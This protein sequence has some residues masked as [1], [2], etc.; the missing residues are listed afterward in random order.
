MKL[1]IVNKM[2]I[3][4]SNPNIQPF[5]LL[6]NK[7][8]VHFIS[9]GITWT[10]VSSYVYVNMFS[11]EHTKALMNEQISDNPFAT[12][13][14]LK[15]KEDTIYYEQEILNGL[16]I[17]FSQQPRLRARLYETRGKELVYEDP[18]ILS[19]LNII[20]NKNVIF[21]PIRGV[22]VPRKEVVS[23]IAGVEKKILE[24]PYLDN[25]LK[26]KDLIQY[27]VQNSPDIP[28]SDEIFINV[29]NIV[30]IL[31]FRLREKILTNNIQKFKNHLIDVYLDYL[32]ETEYPNVKKSDYRKAKFQQIVKEKNIE[33]YENQLFDMYL[34]NKINII[35]TTRLKFTPDKNLEEMN[36]EKKDIDSLLKTPE[37]EGETFKVYIGSQNL[38]LPSFPEEV[39][40]NNKTFNTVVHYAYFKL[41]QRIKLNDRKIDVNTIPLNKLQEMYDYEKNIWMKEK[42]KLNNEVAT[43]AKFKQ[44]EILFHLLQMTS[45]WSPS[46]QENSELIWNDKND[47]VLGSGYDNRGENLTGRF[48]EYLKDQPNLFGINISNRKFSSDNVWY[49]SWLIFKSQDYLNTIKL[50]TSKPTLTDL[51][52][53]Y[54]VNDSIQLKKKMTPSK[55]E[56]QKM[57]IAGLTIEEINLIFPLIEVSK[58]WMNN[59]NEKQVIKKWVEDNEKIYKKPNIKLAENNL[60]LIFDNINKNGSRLEC[61]ENTFIATILAG[62]P[63]DDLNDAKW[64]RI[65]YWS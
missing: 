29:N 23:V 54:R 36:N 13:Q 38:F 52:I 5:G 3:L 12:M 46:F 62:K 33:K 9:D 28:Y 50:F 58:K 63:S 25:N 56:F 47:P 37:I 57:K 51:E 22:E 45:T 44:N 65:K 55:R 60:K 64:Q 32:L 18:K 61:N 15:N 39:T 14:M 41:M 30:P 21:D 31:K 42:L 6:S 26:Y 20:R 53:I 35:V 49:D 43:I 2:S 11:N 24:N 10:S 34:K 40:V 4:L 16:S 8:N 59:M 1:K 17:R 19:L 48:L 7:A 27:A